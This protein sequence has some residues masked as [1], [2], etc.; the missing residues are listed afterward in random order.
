MIELEEPHPTAFDPVL[1]GDL[2][3]F[4][5][6]QPKY[7]DYPELKA[8]LESLAEAHPA[9]TILSSLG[10]TEEGRDMLAL[11]LGRPSSEPR[12]EVL[13]IGGL[14]GNEV[15]GNELLLGLA[16]YLLATYAT[17]ARSRKVLDQLSIV[18]VPSANP[19]GTA[20]RWRSNGKGIDL[21][22][23][24]L[25]PRRT[26]PR[27]AFRALES[28]NIARLAEKRR[29]LLSAVFHGGEIVVNYPWDHR[30]NTTSLRPEDAEVLRRLSLRYAGRNEDMAHNPRF[31]GGVTSGYEWYQIRGGLQDYFYGWYGSLNLTIE[32][33]RTKWPVPAELPRHWELNCEA[34]LD[35]L[36]QA[37]VGVALQVLGAEGTPLE[38]T[39]RL[40][41]TRSPLQTAPHDGAYFRLLPGGWHH[42][43][44]EAPGYRTTLVPLFSTSHPGHIL[45]IVSPKPVE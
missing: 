3:R 29:F 15:V 9:M 23:D 17:E 25:D 38:A 41:G 2:V 12:P 8:A 13:L 31:P 19:D 28:R 20:R 40:P 44:I 27:E 18:I 33:S 39:V 4:P 16:R 5:Y 1:A 10:K 45:Q 30:P 14:H 26:R 22:R 43:T 42:A 6:V 34:L 37:R 24:F 35:F 11:R 7:H 36:E 32:V 21:N